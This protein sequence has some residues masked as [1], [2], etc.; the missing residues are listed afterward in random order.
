M[1]ESEKIKTA[2]DRQTKAVEL[3][4][5][6]G[7]GTAV[8]TARMRDGL[9][10]DVEEG[11]WKFTVDAGEK[12]G[13][14]NR[15]PN[16]GVFGRGA[17]AS[18]LAQAYVFWAARLGVPL[19]SLEVQVHAD[20]DTRGMCGAG[21]VPAGYVGIR[22][23]VS[24]E[25]PAPKEEVERMLDEADAHSPYLDVFMRALPTKR[26]VHIAEGGS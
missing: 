12:W 18:C 20:Y 11:E 1:S 13:G 16:P 5:S 25:S 10:I 23:V 21:E 4:A 19:S 15:G 2:F 24:L 26:E 6:V 3:R 17:L 8:T 7:C 22:Y 14:R 9:T